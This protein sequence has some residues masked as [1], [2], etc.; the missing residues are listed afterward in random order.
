MAKKPYKFTAARKAALKRAQ[1]A[2]AAKRRKHK[3]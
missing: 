3:K 2:A 1:K